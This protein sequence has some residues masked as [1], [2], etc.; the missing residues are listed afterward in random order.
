MST[1]RSMSAS[2]AHRVDDVGEQRVDEHDLRARVAQ[3]ERQLG[4]AEPQVQRVDDSGAEEAGVVQLEVLVPVPRDDR[5][6]VAA[7]EPELGPQR[8]ASRSTRSRCAPN[9][10]W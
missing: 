8:G 10:A 9:V 6:P 2:R 7:A 5:V 1:T 4:R 3:D